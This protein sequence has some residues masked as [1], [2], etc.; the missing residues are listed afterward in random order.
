MRNLDLIF[1]SAVINKNKTTIPIF[2]TDNRQLTTDIEL[3]RLF[4]NFA[5]DFIIRVH[6]SVFQKPIFFEQCFALP[7]QAGAEFAV[8]VND[9]LVQVL[10]GGFDFAPDPFVRHFHNLGGLIDG[11]GFF[12]VFQN[13]GAAFADDDIAVIINN[14]V[15]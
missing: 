5:E 4:E 6:A 11:T 2:T 1:A 3:A 10:F 15:T 7:G 14:P 13:F 9:I 8:G 12:N